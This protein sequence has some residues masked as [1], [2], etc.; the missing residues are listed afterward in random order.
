MQ[1]ANNV[2]AAAPALDGSGILYRLLSITFCE[3]GTV[4]LVAYLIDNM[5]KHD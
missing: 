3:T 4:A 5:P 1:P 2:V